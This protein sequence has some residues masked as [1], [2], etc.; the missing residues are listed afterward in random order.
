MTTNM[1]KI[2]E[3][4]NDHELQEIVKIAQL[5]KISKEITKPYEDKTRPIIATK[6]YGQEVKIMNYS[7]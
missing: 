6:D 4:K 1:N 3:L 5:S 2:E 7:N